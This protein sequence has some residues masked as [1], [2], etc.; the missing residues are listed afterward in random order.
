MTLRTHAS[1]LNAFSVKAA[2]SGAL[3]F[4][5]DHYVKARVVGC[6]YGLVC[7]TAYIPHDPAHVQRKADCF[8]DFAGATRI[9]GH[10]KTILPKVR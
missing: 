3:S 6:D 9:N 8:T 5:L 2:S 1:G 7:H 10:F 4:Y